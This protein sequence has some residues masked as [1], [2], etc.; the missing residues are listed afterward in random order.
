MPSIVILS[1]SSIQVIQTSSGI[2]TSVGPPECRPQ[3]G[4]RGSV[5]TSVDPDPSSFPS[6]CLIIVH[7]RE[8]LIHFDI[9]VRDAYFD[10]LGILC[11]FF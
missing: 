7:V 8:H 4:T 11:I 2:N 5:D 9:S 6:E 3:R 10:Y 1:W